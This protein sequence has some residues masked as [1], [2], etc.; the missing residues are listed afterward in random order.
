M[1][2]DADPSVHAPT[3]NAHLKTIGK[4][5]RSVESSQKYTTIYTWGTTKLVQRTKNSTFVSAVSQELK[6]LQSL[7][8]GTLSVD[9]SSDEDEESQYGMTTRNVGKRKR[10]R[11]DDENADGNDEESNNEA[12]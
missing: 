5:S 10:G 2:C 4:V 9:P 3:R 6:S 12:E 1:M 8:N 7:G 11:E